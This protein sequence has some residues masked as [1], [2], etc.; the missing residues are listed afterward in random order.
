MTKNTI[1]KHIRGSSIKENKVNFGVK[2]TKVY[3]DLFS[4]SKNLSLLYFLCIYIICT[5]YKLD[6]QTKLAVLSI[7][8]RDEILKYSKFS[9]TRNLKSLSHLCNFNQFV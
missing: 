7:L 3:L 5:L 1:I 8:T 9:Y 6:K 2:F 4:N